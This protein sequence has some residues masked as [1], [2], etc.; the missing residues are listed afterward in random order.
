M[1]IKC[2]NLNF[3]GSI[4]VIENEDLKTFTRTV[5]CKK[6][7]L[8]KLEESEKYTVHDKPVTKEFFFSECERLLNSITLSKYGNISYSAGDCVI[9]AGV[10]YNL[11]ER[12]P[13]DKPFFINFD[14]P[15]SR[16]EFMEV[17]Y[18]LLYG[19]RTKT[20]DYYD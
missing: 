18:K 10:S 4:T 8:D 12:I 7:N 6:P 9:T 17:A 1:M 5:A 20:V 3:T 15:A 19:S 13:D 16:E 11:L 2:L 14:Q